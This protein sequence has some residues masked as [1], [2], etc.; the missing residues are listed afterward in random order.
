MV[1]G[2]SMYL[3]STR[4]NTATIQGAIEARRIADTIADSRING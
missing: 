3:N 1:R 2:T 4:A